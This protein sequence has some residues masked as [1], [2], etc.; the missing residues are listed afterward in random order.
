[1]T[2]NCTNRKSCCTGCHV[3]RPDKGGVLS[4]HTATAATN[5]ADPEVE[6]SYI[7]L[8]DTSFKL[9]AILQHHARLLTVKSWNLENHPFLTAEES[10]PT[11]SNP[12]TYVGVMMW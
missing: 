9:L 3:H 6:A 2:P 4:N 1:M 12:Q 11:V 5:P 7:I 10:P 8:V